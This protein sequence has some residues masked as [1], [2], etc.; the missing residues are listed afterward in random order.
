MR[1]V[2]AQSASRSH[3]TSPIVDA[4]AG[5][6]LTGA[7]GTVGIAGGAAVGA[8]TTGVAEEEVAGPAF[9]LCTGALGP[10]QPQATS[11]PRPQAA[12]Q[13]RV[14][15]PVVIGVRLL[16]ESYDSASLMSMRRKPGSRQRDPRSLLHTGYVPIEALCAGR[17]L[18]LGQLQAWITEGRLP[19]APYVLSVKPAGA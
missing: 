1:V 5:S 7:S 6:E 14:S 3:V 8:A 19:Q 12:I 4:D 9:S 17:A 11:K 18:P 13:R 2:I 16:D 15:I 10:V